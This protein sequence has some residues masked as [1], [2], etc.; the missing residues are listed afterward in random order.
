[1]IPSAPVVPLQPSDIDPEPPVTIAEPEPPQT[2]T[3]PVDSAPS[4]LAVT[5]SL[6][7][8][9]PAQ[10][11]SPAPEGL[12]D[13]ASENTE[14]RLAPSQLIESPLTAYRRD[15][16]NVFGQL[17]GGAQSGRQGFG[18][19]LGAGNSDATNYAGQVLVHLNRTAPVPVTGKGW[20]RVLFLINPDGSLA[21]VDVLD[22]SGS[23]P[24][25]RAVR[26][27]VRSAAPFPPPARW[28]Q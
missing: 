7:P 24:I 20:A 21:S 26:E 28:R 8:R 16:A 6:R 10:R 19:A 25:E 13:G 12:P 3:D 27:Q 1:M 15:G 18:A 17:G 22:S 11:P 2:P 14:A 5:T 4:D 23:R 9:L